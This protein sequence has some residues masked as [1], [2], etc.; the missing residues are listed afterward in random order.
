[1][2]LLMADLERP[3]SVHCIRCGRKTK[4]KATGRPPKYCSASCKVMAHTKRTRVLK[5][6]LPPVALNEK[7]RAAL[8]ETLR[9]FGLVHGE[10]PKPKP[11]QERRR[12]ALAGANPPTQRA[13]LEVAPHANRTYQTD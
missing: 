10:M 2:E 3:K 5:Q 8:W 4:V 1:M 12:A 7:Q 9:D 6:A 11:E 13:T